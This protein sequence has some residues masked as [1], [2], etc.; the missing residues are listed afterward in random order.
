VVAEGATNRVPGDK[1]WLSDE[2]GWRGTAQRGIEWL[3]YNAADLL[4]AADQPETLR[5]A[6]TAAAPRPVLLIAGGAVADEARAGRFIQ[7]GSPT[8]VQLWVAPATGHTDALA[9]HPAEWESRV[10]SFLADALS[11]EGE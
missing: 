2:F 5:A 1:A 9:T 6:V 10:T 8:S 7:G 11:G 3:L 4:T